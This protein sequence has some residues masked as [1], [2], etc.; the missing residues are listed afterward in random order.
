[1]TRRLRPIESENL[2]QRAYLA[3]RS[4]L[5]D[6]RYSPG[7]RLRLR[8]L[9][10]ELGV[11]VTPVREAVLQ[12]VGDGALEMRTPRDI[13]VRSLTAGDY[14]DT[15]L[16]R[17]QLEGL[18]V[19]RFAS[20]MKPRQL[21]ELTAIEEKHR[22]ALERRDYRTAVALDRRFMFTIFEAVG[23]PILFETLDRLWLVARPT[24][25]LLYSDRGVAGTELGNQ[26]LLDALAAGDGQAAADARHTQ[27]AECAEVIVSML[28]EQ[29][30]ND[31]AINS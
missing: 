22:S 27:I 4:A 20:R 8:D 17:Q 24:V 28:R 3:I 19:R 25:G 31:V 2:G 13:R 12:L 18:A 7:D 16:I 26:A 21:A 15:A 1:M 10:Q 5:V 6:G 23:M 30:N 29:E 14:S 11:S 9:A